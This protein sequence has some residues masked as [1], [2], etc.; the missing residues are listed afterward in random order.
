MLSTLLLSLLSRSAALQ[1]FSN[2]H[3]APKTTTER[4]VVPE[5]VPLAILYEDEDLL[6]IDKAAGMVVQ[7]VPSSV[8]RAVVAHLDATGACR[9]DTPA[10]AATWG[11]ARAFEG[12]VH[13]L[14]KGTSGCMAVAKHP[15][16]ARA[17]RR[18]F[19]ERRV[20]KTYLALAVGL[21]QRAAPAE[22]TSPS[23]A[24]ASQNITLEELE[25]DPQQMC[26]VNSINAC[27]K[28]TRRAL[29]LL[30]G[31]IR[32]G[33]AC[34][35]AALSVCKRAGEVGAALS[36][37][38]SMAARGVAP[39]AACFRTV[40]ALCPLESPPR[41]QTA[42]ELVGEMEARGLPR[43]AH[44]ICS[45]MSA[46]GRAAQLAAALDLFALVEKDYGDAVG[47]ATAAG[48]G[49]VV[50]DRGRLEVRLGPGAYRACLR[51]AISACERCD[52]AEGIAP[53]LLA[54]RRRVI[55]LNGDEHSPSTAA[56]VTT[57]WAALT[58]VPIVVD[59]PIGKEASRFWGVVPLAEGGRPARSSVTPLAFD[60]TLS[61]NKVTI[62]TGRT[63]QI[64]V[65]MSAVLGAPLVGDR[66]YGASE[67]RRQRRGGG[68]ATSQPVRR[69]MLHA[70]ELVLP[71]PTSGE[72]LT[73]QCPPPAD[74][75]ALT[76]RVLGGDRSGVASRLAMSEVWASER[77]WLLGA[78]PVL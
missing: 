21:P 17:L 78:L 43:D 68:M 58:S 18:A 77:E 25:V 76:D 39:N 8:E 71:H 26:L 64:R 35:S 69:A 16:A 27:G 59:V 20:G 4:P 11:G 2:V 23:K 10:W 37:L 40:I 5:R 15:R 45:A 24:A 22:G 55:A 61:L 73:L 36:L 3:A 42:V 48:T 53:E 46:C 67:R 57:D 65:H 50:S 31:A 72:T 70:A 54:E 52:A 30:D 60:G 19:R 51:S 41:W 7:D 62:E 14:D 74:F 47:S 38:S 32:P 6:V 44:C 63:H 56:A 13:R 9:W 75:A 33:V 12:V 1:A 28:D 34:F 66:A 29:A 49:P